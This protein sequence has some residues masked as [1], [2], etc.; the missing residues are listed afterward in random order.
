[1]Q[2]PLQVNGIIV[3]KTSCDPLYR[4]SIRVSAGATLKI[5]YTQGA[6]IHNI[7]IALHDVDF[8]LYALSPS[9]PST[10]K[11]AKITKGTPLILRT[12]GN[13]LPNHVLQKSDTLRIPMAHGFDSLNVAT[14]SG[15]ALAYFSNLDKL[16]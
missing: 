6:D 8:Y 2:L 10:L 11:Q 16:Y 4:K 14:A 13:G 15:I 12:E 1:M 3:D 7:I 9:S 5:P